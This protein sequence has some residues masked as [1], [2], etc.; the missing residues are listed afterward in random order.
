MF[1]LKMALCG[2]VFGLISA[3]AQTTQAQAAPLIDK[4]EL[5]L[6]IGERPS[7]AFAHISNQSPA[8]IKLMR[9]TSPSFDKIELHTHKMENNIMR[10]RK[11][12]VFEIAPNSTIQL[13]RGGKHLMLFGYQPDAENGAIVLQ[14]HFDNGE[15]RKKWVWPDKIG[16]RVDNAPISKRGLQ[17]PAATHSLINL[18]K[19]T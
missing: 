18:I 17:S 6:N 2:L 14:F 11:V 9:V 5:L 3:P 1:N 13:K 15:T 19:E 8:P 10:M 16:K 4:L 7:I 12:E